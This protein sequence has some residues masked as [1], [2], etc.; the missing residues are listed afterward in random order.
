[1][2]QTGLKY[3]CFIITAIVMSLM[4]F[5]VPILAQQSEMMAGRMAGEQAARA[6]V[7]GML[8][9]LVGC[10]GSVIGLVL[11]YYLEPSPSA[12]QLLGKSPEYAAAFTDA[13][14]ATAKSIQTRNAWTGCIV[15]GVVYAGCS[16]WYALAVAATTTTTV[17]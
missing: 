4:I 9:F 2:K 1:M 7:N 6:S 12:T 14:K 17:Y 16:V 10:T 5:A 15:T 3:K 13:Y 11:A 8:W